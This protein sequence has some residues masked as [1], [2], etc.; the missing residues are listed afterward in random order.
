MLP[1]AMFLPREGSLLSSHLTAIGQTTVVIFH[2]NCK[3][4]ITSSAFCRAM[5][6]REIL[7]PSAFHTNFA[8]PCK[9]TQIFRLQWCRYQITDYL[10]ST[11]HHILL[12]PQMF[13]IPLALLKSKSATIVLRQLCQL[14]CSL[15]NPQYSKISIPK[16]NES[17]INNYLNG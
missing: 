14:K 8:S 7:Q 4:L 2:K 3:C 16:S 17:D 12:Q 11:P 13:H 1:T 5:K 15:R 6:I 10:I 9:T